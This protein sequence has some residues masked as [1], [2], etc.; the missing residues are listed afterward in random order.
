M[1]VIGNPPYSGE[2]ANKGDWIM[3]LMEAY[4]KEPGGVQKLQERNPK[5]INITYVK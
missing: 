2:S 5:W 4:K 1:C 3:G